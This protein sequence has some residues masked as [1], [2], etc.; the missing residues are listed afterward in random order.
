MNEQN[1]IE[2]IPSAGNLHKSYPWLNIPQI[3]VPVEEL[4]CRDSLIKL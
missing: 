3:D 4:L 1:L 2:L